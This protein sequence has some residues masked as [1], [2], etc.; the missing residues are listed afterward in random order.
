MHDW[1]LPRALGVV[2]D[3]LLVEVELGVAGIDGHRDGA[4]SPYS[5]L[6]VLGAQKNYE[7]GYDFKKITPRSTLFLDR[8]QIL[9]RFVVP[10]EGKYSYFKIT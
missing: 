4:H 8:I 6:Q 7:L 10:G 1:V 9:F 2:V 3:S 5:L